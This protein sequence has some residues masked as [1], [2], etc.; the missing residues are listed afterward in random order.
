[1]GGGKIA[2]TYLNKITG[3]LIQIRVHPYLTSGKQI[4]VTRQLPYPLSG[5]ADVMRILT[6]QEYYQ[7]D[8]PRVTRKYQ[9]GVYADEV[10]QHYFP[11]SIAIVDNGAPTV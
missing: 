6:R 11:P 1:M 7:V 10:L 3:D 8:W 4:F 5:V 2:T 9:F